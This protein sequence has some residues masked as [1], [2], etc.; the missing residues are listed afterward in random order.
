MTHKR[1]PK[2]QAHRYCWAMRETLRFKD[3]Q[4]VDLWRLIWLTERA[5]HF[6]F[7]DARFLFR[8]ATVN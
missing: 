1:P 7:A 2:G 8:L 5:Q 4:G 6:I 3:L